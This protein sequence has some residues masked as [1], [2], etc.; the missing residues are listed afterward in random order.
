MT[1]RIYHNLLKINNII[2]K[3]VFAIAMARKM[4]N[5]SPGKN[6]GTAERWNR[7]F[8]KDIIRLHCIVKKNFAI[9]PG[10]RYPH[11][12]N[13]TTPVRNSLPKRLR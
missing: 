3:P 2:E 10:V 13:S 5:D 11:I 6:N 12:Q 8:S 7:E 4:K 9:Y 1:S